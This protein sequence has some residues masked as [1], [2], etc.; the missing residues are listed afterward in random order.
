MVEDDVEYCCRD[1]SEVYEG[2]EVD[3][4]PLLDNDHDG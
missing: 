3:I 1:L 2:G 4:D